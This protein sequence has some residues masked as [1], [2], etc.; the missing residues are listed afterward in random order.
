MLGCREVPDLVFPIL[1]Q[2]RWL[3][4]DAFLIELREVEP[5]P[6]FRAVLQA[7]DRR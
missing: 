4:S 2:A 5:S 7:P 3:R 6:S 1:K